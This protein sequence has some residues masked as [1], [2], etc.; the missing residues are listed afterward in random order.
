MLMTTYPHDGL[1]LPYQDN[2]QSGETIVLLHGFPE[3]ITSWAPVVQRLSAAGYRTIVPAMRGYAPK[4]TP[5]DRQAYTNTRLIGDIVA[6]LDHLHLSAVHLVGHDWGGQLA[7]ELAKHFPA[8]FKTLTVL[9]TPHPSALGWACRHSNQLWHSA[10]I[11]AF[12]LPMIP[13]RFLSAHLAAFLT[14]AGLNQPSA[15]R[16]AAHFATPATLRGPL[17][18]YR[19]L[20]AS[21]TSAN[22]SPLIT[23]PTT[24]VWGQKDPFLRAAAAHKTGD[25]VTADYRFLVLNTGHW[26]P[27][28]RPIATTAAILQRVAGRKNRVE[29][30]KS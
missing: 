24:Y 19:G 28:N 9:G 26:L 21:H 15:V 8:R 27:E 17:N 25:W 10:Y 30:T 13:E 3:D 14:R 11:G 1:Q 16:L 7:W 2:E 5:T 22:V 29:P 23:I 6:L 4:A 18:W 20:L 12:W